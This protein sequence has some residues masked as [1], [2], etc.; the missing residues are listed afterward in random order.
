MP[1]LFTP[2]KNILNAC[3]LS[4]EK[5][6]KYFFQ[7]F[8]YSQYYFS[9]TFYSFK[10]AQLILVGF[11]F[12]FHFKLINFFY[13]FIKSFREALQERRLSRENLHMRHLK[14]MED[15]YNC[16]LWSKDTKHFWHA[17]HQH[18]MVCMTEGTAYKKHLWGCFV[19][20]AFRKMM[21]QHY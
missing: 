17:H 19:A 16:M 5:L 10:I 21:S 4:L 11:F 2:L 1:K 8:H 7:V 13:F 12:F 15:Y 20:R 9:L 6:E 3:K 18:V 14:L